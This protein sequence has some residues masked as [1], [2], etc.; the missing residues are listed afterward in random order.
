MSEPGEMFSFIT[1]LLTKQRRA[2]AASCSVDKKKLFVMAMLSVPRVRLQ[3]GNY[4]P[5][6]ASELIRTRMEHSVSN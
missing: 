5:A 6:L 3:N 2:P 1:E 4:K